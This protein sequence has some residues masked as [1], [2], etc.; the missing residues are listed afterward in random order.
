[1]R[2]DI[3]EILKHEEDKFIAPEWSCFKKF[4]YE[5]L[6]K[7]LYGMVDEGILIK[8]DCTGLAFEYAHQLED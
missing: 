1:M 8:R 6:L 7:E 4:D 2:E 3:L 5:D